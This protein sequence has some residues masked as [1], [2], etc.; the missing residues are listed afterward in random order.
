M[1]DWYLPY[2]PDNLLR[3]GPQWVTWNPRNH[4]SGHLKNIRTYFTGRFDRYLDILK[5]PF[6]LSN[7]AI[8]TFKISGEGAIIINGR[9]EVPV[10]KNTA[11]KYFPE[12]A[13][14]VTAVPAEGK[15]FVG[16]KVSNNFGE[17]ADA[18]A[19]TTTFTFTR[20]VQLTAMFE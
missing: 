15:T 6:D 12:Y 19:I 10:T 7:P 9:D 5:Q 2:Q 16:W 8:I 1:T 4:F 3:F 11:L 20:T 18:S 14:T 13:V 17:V